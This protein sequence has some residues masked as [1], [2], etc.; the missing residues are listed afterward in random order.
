M[1]HQRKC[2][3]IFKKKNQIFAFTLSMYSV[4]SKQKLLIYQ[5]CEAGCP[6]VEILL[7]M[8]IDIYFLL[9]VYTRP[10]R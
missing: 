9:R 2:I 8:K 3:N 4:C 1:I 5:K 7:L 10:I 6:E